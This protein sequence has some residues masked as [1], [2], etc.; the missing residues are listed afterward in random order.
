MVFEIYADIFFILNFF[1]NFCVIWTSS[2]ISGKKD[3]GIIRVI[4]GSII[5]TILYMFT[6]FVPF[7]NR[8]Y[9]SISG[10][11]ILVIGIIFVFRPKK[12]REV[13]IQTLI[14]DITSAVFFG[15]TQMFIQFFNDYKSGRNIGFS[16]KIMIFSAVFIYICT[17]VFRKYTSRTLNSEKFCYIEV[18]LNGKSVRSSA[19]I[20]TGNELKDPLSK[21]SAVIIQLDEAISLFNEDTAINLLE[22]IE[23]EIEDILSSIKD[24]DFLSRVRLLPF[25]SVDND[26]GLMLG[27]LS[28]KINI[29]LADGRK[30]EIKGVTVGLYGGRLSPKGI[31]KAIID[32]ES[33]KF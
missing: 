26:K 21:K 17:L 13:F 32:Y 23:K 12:L 8:F 27:F 31:Y 9:G 2:V 11:I 28:D 3:I 15:V 10:Q 5:I 1:M 25:K 16:M 30:R 19:L 24:V 22:N 4:L 6:I 18:Y 7:L 14:T 29:T 33:C 20:D